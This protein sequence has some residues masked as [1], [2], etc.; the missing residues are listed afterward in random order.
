MDVTLNRTDSVNA[1]I[2]IH[3]GKADYENEV[4]NSL[5]DLRRSTV[6]PG[7]RKGMVPLQLL[8]QK[9]GKMVLAEEINKLLSKALSNCVKDNELKLMGEPLPVDSQENISFETQEEFDFSY[10][11]GLAPEITAELTKSDKL[12]YYKIQ[13][14]DEM[15]DKQVEH[16]KAQYGK[17]IQVEEVEERDVVKG[18]LIELDENGEPK[19]GGLTDEAAVLMPSYMKNEDEKAK[20]VNA[21]L[22]STIIFNPY[23]AYDGSEVELASFLKITKDKV[24]DHTGNFSFAISEITRYKE[25]ELDQELYD[26]VFEPGTVSS[27]EM[28]RE[29]IKENLTQ[30][31]VPESDYK[32][33]IDARKLLEEKV[34]DI[35]LPDEFLKR[36]MVVIDSN[37]T[38]ES[39]ENEYSK[40]RSDLIFHMI[41]E[42]LMEKYGI[43]IEDEEMAEYARQ[44]ARAQFAQY[45]ITDIED[46]IVENYAEEML[47]KKETFQTLGDRIFENKLIQVLKKHVTLEPQDISLEDFQKMFNKK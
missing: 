1:T 24:K 39:I 7:F 19:E 5:K 17:H 29:K 40:I 21:K 37:K 6:M 16:F 43:K 23:A 15:I 27:E 32:F 47:N 14:T 41:K 36:W 44:T 22:E 30:Q 45:G 10:Y 20:F 3:V 42:H 9:Y 35:V 46:E 33:F 13:V 25:A 2:N 4:E 38:P 34:V 8:R 28:F 18:K 31:F 26:K 11:I 12:P